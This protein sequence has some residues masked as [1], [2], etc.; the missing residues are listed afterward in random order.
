MKVVSRNQLSSDIMRVTLAIYG[1]DHMGLILS[2][3][4]G[5]QFVRWSLNDDQPVRGP[6][7]NNQETYFVYYASSSGPRKWELYVDFKVSLDR[8]LKT[9]NLSLVPFLPD[10]KYPT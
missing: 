2:P 6:L 8:L 3:K 7:W 5:V 10:S 1:P 4:P 9:S